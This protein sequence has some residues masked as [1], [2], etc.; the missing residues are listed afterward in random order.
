[1]QILHIHNKQKY[2]CKL[3]SLIKKKKK[4]YQKIH[5]CLPIELQH[6]SHQGSFHVHSVALGDTV[7]LTHSTLMWWPCRHTATWL[8]SAAPPGDP[9]HSLTRNKVQTKESS[10]SDKH[11]S[12][13]VLDLSV[14][15]Y[16][17]VYIVQMYSIKDTIQNANI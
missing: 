10:V 4:P 1:M 7:T 11:L 3:F 5:K 17:Y 8:C 12:G 2:F 9:S 15:A 14:S 6:E 13:V 16:V